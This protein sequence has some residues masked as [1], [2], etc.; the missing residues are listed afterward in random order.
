MAAA[1]PV[2]TGD[3]SLQNCCNRL[4]FCNLHNG[5][6]RLPDPISRIWRAHEDFADDPIHPPI[7]DISIFRLGVSSG[8]LLSSEYRSSRFV[9][10]APTA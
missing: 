7:Y 2:L 10:A 1:S 9:Q 5:L 8:W 4:T 6:A 3:S